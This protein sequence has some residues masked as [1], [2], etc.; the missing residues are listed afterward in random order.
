MTQYKINA[1]K[2]RLAA[3]RKPNTFPSKANSNNNDK[4]TSA[5]THSDIINNKDKHSSFHSNRS[6]SWIFSPNIEKARAEQFFLL[7]AMVWISIVFY[8]VCSQW[9]ETFTPF[10]Y[11]AL[12]L[13]LFIF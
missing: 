13:V 6:C 12:G 3:L 1:A 7:W 11:L 9:F 10:H 8:I 2:I 5:D 4:Q